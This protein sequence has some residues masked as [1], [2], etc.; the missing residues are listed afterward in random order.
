[1][2]GSEEDHFSDSSQDDLF[3]FENDD[4]NITSEKKNSTSSFSLVNIPVHNGAKEGIAMAKNLESIKLTA[5]CL[6]T[7]N[8]VHLTNFTS[9]DV[10]ETGRVGLDDFSVLSVL[11]KGAFGKVYLVQKNSTTI[12]YA[13]KVLKKASLVVYQKTTENTLNER[14]IL[15]K[16]KHPFIVKLYYAFQTSSRLYLILTYAQGGELFSFL[17]ES[18]LFTDDIASFYIA[19]LLLA[20]EH[21]HSL[22][23]IY[24][25]LKP[26]N[27]M[28]DCDGHILLTDFGLSK[29]SLNSST[30]CGTVEFMAPEI[31]EERARYDKTVDYWSL[32]IM[33]FDMIVG[34]PPF[35]GSN[36]KKIM[37]SVLKKKPV[38]P[39]YMTATTRDLCTKLLKKNP[40][41]RL[42]SNGIEQIKN[43]RFFG[44]INWSLIIQKK[45]CPPHIPKLHS[46]TDVSNF[47]SE[48]TTMPTRESVLE[49]QEHGIL[50]NQELFRG[51]SFVAPSL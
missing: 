40:T 51:F 48:F 11:G 9:R 6:K 14:H 10:E 15:D 21:L 39:K 50:P 37:E 28:L 5:N 25:D 41:V 3:L 26:E 34:H 29:I 45:I 35:T 32:G 44:K 30:V 12:Y 42:G 19:E 8:E 38:F 20:I 4:I 27:V 23:I 2:R 1:M 31:L 33:L 46:P 16:L 36:R 18:R 47:H 7:D 17:A 43:H 49:L 24:R 13:M 22:G